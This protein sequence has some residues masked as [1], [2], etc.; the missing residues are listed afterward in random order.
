MKNILTL[1]N[2]SKSFDNVEVLKD[3]LIEVK[4]TLILLFLSHLK[5][6]P[7]QRL[8]ENSQLLKK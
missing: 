6:Y 4:L 1:S 5:K 7:V 3:T 8:F 2:I